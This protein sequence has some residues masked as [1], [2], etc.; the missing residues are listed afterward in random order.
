[1]TLQDAM[2]TVIS[3]DV[4]VCRVIK[5][6]NPAWGRWEVMT[7]ADTTAHKA[8]KAL[9]RHL[10]LTADGQVKQGMAPR[11]KLERRIGIWLDKLQS[12]GNVA[13]AESELQDI[14]KQ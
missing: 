10:V 6:W 4:K 14:L 5:C 1:M 12:G 11:G 8:M 7:V 9:I 13:E 2:S 3:R